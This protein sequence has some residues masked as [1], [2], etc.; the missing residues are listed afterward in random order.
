[1][2]AAA[3]RRTE[4]REALTVAMGLTTDEAVRRY[5]EGKRAALGAKE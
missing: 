3:G 5:L 4:A 1:L 2:L